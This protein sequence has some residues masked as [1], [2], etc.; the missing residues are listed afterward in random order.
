MFA[1]VHHLTVVDDGDLGIE[2]AGDVGIEKAVLLDQAGAS[3]RNVE[4][5]A[6]SVTALAAIRD[7]AVPTTEAT[8]SEKASGATDEASVDRTSLFA[9]TEKGF[10]VPTGMQLQIGRMDST[11]PYG[12]RT[13]FEV[14]QLMLLPRDFC[15]E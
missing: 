13:L 15:L 11:T 1:P 2:L 4:P 8:G 3:L 7:Q 6:F 14:G 5:F 9:N 10:D 12:I